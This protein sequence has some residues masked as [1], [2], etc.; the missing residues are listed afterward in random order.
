MSLKFMD[1]VGHPSPPPSATSLGHSTTVNSVVRYTLGSSTSDRSFHVFQWTPSGL[2]AMVYRWNGTTVT[3][4]TTSRQIVTYLD[5]TVN[6]DAISIKPARMSVRLRN[7]TVFTSTA[8]QIR[9]LGVPDPLD[10]EFQTALT[11]LAPSSLL[12]TSIASMIDGHKDTRT[13]TAHD[14][15]STKSFVLAPA[16][17]VGY[18]KWY[19]FNKVGSGDSTTWTNSQAALINGSEAA[20][21]YTLIVCIDASSTANSY[22][23][24][25]HR[26]DLCRYPAN[27]ML[28]SFARPQPKASAD[29]LHSIHTVAASHSGVSLENV[30]EVG[31]AATLADRKSV[32]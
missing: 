29:A 14:F 28:S 2:S 24:T 15:A 31:L 1:P 32:V 5:D 10:W 12:A 13:L 27:H 8:G 6:S 17:A 11:D 25:I 18:N 22:G 4:P 3:L 26:Q 21:F 16:S 19:N 30:A 7:Y 23:F 20:A 9:V